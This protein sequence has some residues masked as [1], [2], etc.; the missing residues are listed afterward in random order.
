MKPKTILPIH[1]KDHRACLFP[2]CEIQ[3]EKNVWP[4]TGSVRAHPHPSSS[5]LPRS[6]SM[7]SQ[8]HA[9][10]SGACPLLSC[11]PLTQLRFRVSARPGPWPL[12]KIPSL[13]RTGGWHLSLKSCPLS[14]SRAA[15]QERSGHP[16]SGS[17]ASRMTGCPLLPT[18]IVCRLSQT[19]PTDKRGGPPGPQLVCEC[20][21][22]TTCQGTR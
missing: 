21:P 16:T 5:G 3:D 8:D 12:L 10:R 15:E 17:R 7:F 9:S 19:H 11:R 2:P 22:W 14:P 20:Y 1:S 6:C 18:Y 4:R 13:H